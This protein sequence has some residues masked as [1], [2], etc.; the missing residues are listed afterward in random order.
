VHVFGAATTFAGMAA[1]VRGR[2]AAAAE[3][4]EWAEEVA[5]GAFFGSQAAEERRRVRKRKR[6][7]IARLYHANELRGRAWKY[8]ERCGL[9][10]L[11]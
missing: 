9:N 4:A 3:G 6:R 10:P 8:A 1:D 2:A 7:C 5:E 11:Q